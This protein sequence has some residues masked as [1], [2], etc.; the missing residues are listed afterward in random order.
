[1]LE[2]GLLMMHDHR[3]NIDAAGLRSPGCEIFGIEDRD[4]DTEVRARV[5][6]VPHT[7]HAPYG[8]GSLS[9]ISERHE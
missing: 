9:E 1:M 8:D 3:V 5:F 7:S 6:K 2:N 4:R